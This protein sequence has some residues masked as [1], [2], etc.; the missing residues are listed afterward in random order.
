MVQAG[1]LDEN[2]EKD[3]LKKFGELEKTFEWKSYKEMVDECGY[4][5]DSEDFTEACTFNN[6]ETFINWVEIYGFYNYL[7]EPYDTLLNQYKF[8]ESKDKLYTYDRMN[9]NLLWLGSEYG[10]DGTTSGTPEWLVNFHTW[11]NNQS[12][13]GSGRLQISAD[14]YMDRL[15]RCDRWNINRKSL[16][17]FYVLLF[18]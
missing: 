9:P 10:H 13:G 8:N 18:W 7:D 5:W 11:I 3:I 1:P 15:T 17:S 12:I 4:Y 16:Y 14:G 2:D 6:W